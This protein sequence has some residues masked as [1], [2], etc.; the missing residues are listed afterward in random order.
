MATKTKNENTTTVTITVLLES[1]DGIGGVVNRRGL[2][3]LSCTV[4]GLRFYPFLL[5]NIFSSRRVLSS[6]RIEHGSV[7]T[8]TLL[9]EKPWSQIL[10][11]ALFSTSVFP[12]ESLLFDREGKA[13]E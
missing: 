2:D 1:Q 8:I 4:D 3:P 12:C 9:S 13:G 10:P 6:C 7:A 5:T 11:P